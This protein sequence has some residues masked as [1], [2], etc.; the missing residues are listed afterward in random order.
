[1]EWQSPVK[2][3]FSALLGLREDVK[4]AFH[5]WLSLEPERYL[6]DGLNFAYLRILF[7]SA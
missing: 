5:T 7:R 1:M 2:T 6:P 4:R 3:V